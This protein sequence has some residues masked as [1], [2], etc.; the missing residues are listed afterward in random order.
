M[1]SNEFPPSSDEII[2]KPW[3]FWATLGLSAIIF[4]LFSGLQFII[5]IV[6]LYLAKGQRPELDL[7][8][9]ANILFSNG[10]FIACFKG[11]DTLAW[12]R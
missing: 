4:A 2:A 5:V 8:A 9:Y 3:G 1:L 11:F 12:V 7:Q 6:F 10:F